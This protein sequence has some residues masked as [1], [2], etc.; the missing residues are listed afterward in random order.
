[1]SEGWFANRGVHALMHWQPLGYALAASGRVNGVQMR[2]TEFL[3]ETVLHVDLVIEAMGL[4]VVENLLPPTTVHSTPLY[5]AGAMVNGGASVGQCVAEG[6]SV[7]EAI[8][9][10]L[11]K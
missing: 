1:M 5:T 4:E 10:D 7:A 2:H 6:I 8:H 9:R 3:L 11:V